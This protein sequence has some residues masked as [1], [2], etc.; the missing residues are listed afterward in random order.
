VLDVTQ[1]PLL[2]VREIRRWPLGTS[3]PAIITDLVNLFGQHPLVGST[4]VVDKTGVGRPILD[5]L[6]QSG[7][8]ADIRP[9]VIT[10][11]LKPGDGT[12]P[13]RD[14]VA[15]VKAAS[16]RE[17]LKVADGLPLGPVL[18]KELQ[19]FTVKV[20]SDRN[21][22]FASWR[23]KDKDDIVLALALAVWYATEHYS[24][25]ELTRQANAP[26]VHKSPFDDLP[27]GVFDRESRT[28]W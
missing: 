27:R 5:Y 1:R 20:T 9:Y 10:C 21:E 4:L 16:G 3:Y 13:K 15:S 19:T 7:I 26:N 14:L 6:R 24:D 12:V 22:T 18:W 23:E 8:N 11:G 2:Q 17:W 25:P 28:G